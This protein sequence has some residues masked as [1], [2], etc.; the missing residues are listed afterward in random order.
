MICSRSKL[1]VRLFGLSTESRNPGQ[2]GL[3]MI[4]IDALSRKQLEK[5]ITSGRMPF[6]KSLLTKEEYQLHTWYSGMPCSTPVVQAELFYG[7]PGSMVSFSFRDH[8]TNDV[9]AMYNPHQAAEMEDRLQ[10]QALS[11]LAGG[12]A[13]SDI[14][15]GGADETH[16]CITTLG[17]RTIFK[18][19]YPFGFLLLMVFNLYSLVRTAVLMMIEAGLAIYDFFDGLIQGHSLWKELKFVPSRV[20]ICAFLREMITIG[21]K[22]DIA[23]GLPVIHLNYMGY[24]EQS[25]RRGATSLFAHWTLRGIDEAIERVWKAAHCSTLRDYSVWLYSDHG[26]VDSMPYAKAHGRSVQQAA[27][28]SLNSF[29]FA[30][31][32]PVTEALGPMGHIYIDSPVPEHAWDRVAQALIR[33]A[34][35]PV[36]LMAEADGRVRVWRQEDS[37]YLPDEGGRLFDTAPPFYKQMLEDFLRIFKHPDC[38]QIVILGGDPTSETY[39]SFATESGS[40]GGILPEEAEG[41]AL[42]PSDVRPDRLESGYIRPTDLRNEALYLLHRTDRPEQTVHAAVASKTLRVMSYNVHGC[43]GMD[44]HLSPS[45][46]ARVIAQYD[47]HIVAMQELDVGRRRSGG[48]DQAQLIAGYL[49][50]DHH[51]HPTLRIEEES[52]GDAVLSAYPLKLVKRQSLLRHPR[53]SFLEPRGALWVEVEFEGRPVQLINTHLGLLKQERALHTEELLGDRWLGS[54]DCREPVVVCGDFNALPGSRVVRRFQSRLR[55]IGDPAVHKRLRRKGTWFGRYP[56]IRLDHIFVSPGCR[57]VS[58][59]VCDSYLSRIAS[60]HRPLLVEIAL[61]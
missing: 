49:N 18:H 21:A 45:R 15:S 28:E 7:Q 14:F 9:F 34:H 55:D 39:Y 27:A 8:E 12:S 30:E 50:M 57:I 53:F 5:A 47:P 2:N 25:H 22:I 16:F 60:D 43:V 51:F 42:L 56:L 38:G 52:F 32:D 44:G 24:H 4:Q 13:Y 54:A 19:R 6:L 17:A 29:D 61:E 33:E 1:L 58:V 41:F 37:F 35:I 31:R 20:V 46:I 59:D 48:L 26:Q 23:R 3:I 10:H 40:H 11:L 36:V